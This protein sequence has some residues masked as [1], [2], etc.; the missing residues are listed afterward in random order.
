MTQKQKIIA[1]YVIAVLFIVTNSLVIFTKQSY[2][3]NVVPL[4]IILVFTIFFALDKALLFTVFLVPLSVPLEDFMPELGFNID[5]PTEPI[6]VSILIVFLIKQLYDKDFDRKIL[7]HPVS[8]SVYIYL[9][10]RLITVFTSTMPLVSFKYWIASIWF[11]IPFYFLMTQV[12]RK[13]E[14]INKFFWY[15]IIP[16]IIVITYTLIVHSGYLFS[17]KSA[18]YVMAPFYNDHTSYGA[19]LAMFIPIIIGFV[20]NKE[21]KKSL[22]IISGFVLAYFLLAII[23]SYT[24]AA[25]ISLLGALCVFFVLKFKINY[26]FVLLTFAVVIG[27]FFGFQ[28]KIF[29]ALEGNKQDSSTDF[30]EHVRSISNVATDASN[31][32]RIN[33]WNCA[34]RMYKEKPVF[35]WGPGTYQ[36]N[37]APF[38]FSYE[39]TIIS[40]NAGDMGNAHSEYLGTLSESGLPGMICFIIIIVVIFV[41]GIKNY[42]RAKSYSLRILMASVICGFTTYLLH[43]FLNNFL[44]MDK[45][46]VPFWGFT[47]IIVV[48]DVYYYKN[49]SNPISENK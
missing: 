7:L 41:T 19:M 27:L 28:D 3:F 6:F 22:R 32:E 33:R 9:S 10:W 49:K 8:I 38:Q 40:T 37:Y 39:K 4:F 48:V 26:K 47:A 45:A 31:L 42:Q 35:G 11:I 15:Y 13:K 30:K 43:G 17:Q 29:F 24:R 14:N 46:A 20:V 21:L 25:W 34:V 16:F 1:F 5:L 18:N 23:L 12:L 36:F 44:D 2:L